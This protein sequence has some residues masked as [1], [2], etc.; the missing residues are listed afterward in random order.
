MK[1]SG[2]H[3]GKKQL[4]S[5]EKQKRAGI[6]KRPDYL[7]AKSVHQSVPYGGYTP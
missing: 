4:I 1:P 3:I 6:S 2:R 7:L 5:Y